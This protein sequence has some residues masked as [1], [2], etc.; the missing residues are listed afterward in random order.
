MATSDSQQGFAAV[1]SFRLGE[2][3][4]KYPW[5]KVK[6]T[7]NATTR[8]V[9][10]SMI[11]GYHEFACTVT[12]KDASYTSVDAVNQNTN[13]RRD[14]LLDRICHVDSHSNWVILGVPGNGTA[15]SLQLNCG[16]SSKQ[17]AICLTFLVV[18][19]MT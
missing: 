17:A 14:S 12:A 15:P 5:A 8:Q 6:E 13:G 11:Y 7:P 9:W 16:I 2:L 19:L 1:R 10:G 4:E 18:V 3:N